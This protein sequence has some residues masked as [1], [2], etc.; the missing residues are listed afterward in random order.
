[1][2]EINFNGL[3]GPSHNYAGFSFSKLASE[4]MRAACHIPVQ[5]RFK[6]LC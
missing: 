2:T 4:K 1:M 3:V 5:Q 6:A